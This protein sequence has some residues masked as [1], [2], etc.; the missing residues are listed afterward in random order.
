[1]ASLSKNE[2]NKTL[3]LIVIYNAIMIFCSYLSQVGVFILSLIFYCFIYSV[4]RGKYDI[5]ASLLGCIVAAIPTSF[6]S[7]L[8]TSYGELP[9]NWFSIG[10]L[11]LLVYIVIKK[12]VNGTYLLLIIM[13]IVFFLISFTQTENY[14]SA[15]KQG[16]TIFLF[17]LSFIIGY[18]FKKS[19][20]NCISLIQ[21]VYMASVLGTAFQ[22]IL[23]Y[24]YQILFGQTVGRYSVWV[25]R[26]AYSGLFTDY[27]FASL[28]LGTGCLFALIMYFELKSIKLRNLMCLEVLL[29]FPLILTTARTGLYTTIVVCA[30]YI[31]LKFKNH[32][33]KIVPVII[34]GFILIPYMWDIFL[35]L[36][37]NKN[38]FDSSGRLE[39]YFKALEIFEENILIGIG[40]GIE[41]WVEQTNIVIPHNFIIQYLGQFGL[42][43]SFIILT[44]LMVFLVKDFNWKGEMK[45][46]FFLT[47]FGSMFIPDIV[48]S[49]FLFVIVILCMLD[50]RKDIRGENG[51]V[52]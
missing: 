18:S 41:N 44:F 6:L 1:M 37:T 39:S 25:S 36:R 33:K 32:I 14:I 8:G 22:I 26:V 52:H 35:Q 7:V 49:R 21:K 11:L 16:I 31:L 48:S 29:L 46:L 24:I 34:V 27:S 20:Y 13:Y 9:I 19:F 15:I 38:I 47:M 42:L 45:W 10:V 40:F 50:K 5:M 43:G 4:L 2:I 30:L 23:Q 28:Y 12:R 17:L 3:L 51:V